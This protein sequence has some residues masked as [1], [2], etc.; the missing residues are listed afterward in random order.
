M[1]LRELKAA[2]KP[3]H[4]ALHNIAILNECLTTNFTRPRYMQ[5]LS[6]YFAIYSSIE[7]SL[8]ENQKKLN[9]ELDY[10][11]RIKYP[12]IISDLDD[13]RYDWSTPMSIKIESERLIQKKQH[14]LGVA[15]V[16]EGSTL[17]AQII[18]NYLARSIGT[19]SDFAGKFF[20]GYGSNT[21]RNWNEF[22]TFLESEESEEQTEII[23]AAK[24]TF[25]IF[26]RTLEAL[27]D[28]TKP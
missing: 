21:E 27:S 3:Q 5:L 23:K 18:A 28:A 2:T 7:M 1:I 14:W 26:I 4:Q 20:N 9:I 10:S 15:Y 6:G 17:G 11:N 13:L 16:I 8:L 24:G 25:N 12:W 19:S 22:R